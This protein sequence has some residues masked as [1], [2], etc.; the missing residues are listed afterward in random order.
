MLGEMSVEILKSA[1]VS[2]TKIQST[3]FVFDYP[4]LDKSLTQLLH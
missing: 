4:T 3:G 1:K 2:S